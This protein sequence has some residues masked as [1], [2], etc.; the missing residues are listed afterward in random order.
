LETPEYIDLDDTLFERSDP[1]HMDLPHLRLQAEGIRRRLVLPA[2]AWAGWEFNV[3][4]S[5]CPDPL[6]PCGDLT[7]DCTPVA[8]PEGSS[9]GS[10]PWQF[11]LD[12]ENRYLVVETGGNRSRNERYLGRAFVD[13]LDSSGW[14][15]L[16][17][18]F[19]EVR[20][21]Q[22]EAADVTELEAEFP[23]EVLEDA[24][25]LVGYTEILP[26][27][28]LA[29]FRIGDDVWQADDAYCVA[30]KCDCT[31][32]HLT[33]LRILHGGRRKAEFD[34]DKVPGFRYSYRTGV[35]EE[36]GVAPTDGMPSL[37]ELL[38]AT[39]DLVPSLDQELELRHSQLRIL[40]LRELL[41]LS[42][43]EDAAL[44]PKVGRNDPCPCGSGKKYKRCCGA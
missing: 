42:E 6:C 5:V 32:A 22:T 39:R 26:H 14:T 18:Y 43:E 17:A 24:S 30:P 40:Y 29:T 28:I 16:R 27:G 13:A 25:V 41:R 4:L 37:D 23:D 33:F 7:F 35:I 8:C 10:T 31:T 12:T 3:D 2:K 1:E 21:R 19:M 15:K 44:S 36:V 11:I 34:H 38:E 9:P 20:R